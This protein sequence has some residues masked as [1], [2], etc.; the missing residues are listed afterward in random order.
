MSG[1]FGLV[2]SHPENAV[3]FDRMAASLRRHQGQVLDSTAAGPFRIGYWRRDAAE[4]RAWHLQ[5]R[6]DGLVV[7]LAGEI[8]STRHP[9]PA[10]ER[11]D[12]TW[13]LTALAEAFAE[14]GASALLGLNGDFQVAVWE[15]RS[16]RVT[17]AVDRFATTAMYWTATGGAFSFAHGVRGVIAGAGIPPRP[18]LDAIREAVTFGGYRL[19]SRTNIA[20]VHALRPAETVSFSRGITD[21]AIY[22]SLG[23]LA[24]STPR[25]LD[26]AV[27][28]VHAAWTT[29]VQRRLD[30]VTAP[31]QTLSGGR[32]SR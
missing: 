20:N 11:P 19:G 14:R 4:Q 15:P 9:L 1:L 12:A 22:W 30:G 2:D 23:D 13:C 21:R 26:E 28:A 27:D 3:R 10:A 8:F 5:R 29:A 16:H 17:V 6:D 18:D 32:D 7:C 25:S 24:A 31:G